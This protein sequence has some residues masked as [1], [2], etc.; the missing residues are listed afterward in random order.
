[1]QRY[2]ND[3]QDKRFYL[4]ENDSKHIIKVMRMKIN[5]EIELVSNSKLYLC[6]IVEINKKVKVEKI[7]EL[8]SVDATNNVTIVQSL[9]SEQKLSYIIQKAT[10]LGVK[11]IIPLQTTRSKIKITDEK[12][13]LQ[14]W[15]KIAKEASEQSKRINIPKLDRILSFADLNELEGDIK[16]LCTVNEKANYL[17]KHLNNLNKDDRIIIVIGPEGGFTKEEESLLSKTYQ[18]V[19]LGDLVLRTE[20]VSSFVLSI[21]NYILRS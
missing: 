19:S 3:N 6:K 20:T 10:E 21:I 13:K 16:L 9:V 5:D 18:S 17:K 1:M 15:Q 7:K 2:F 8:V 11:E 14:R 12:K 4:D